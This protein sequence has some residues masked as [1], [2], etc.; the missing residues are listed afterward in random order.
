[1]ASHDMDVS[2]NPGPEGLH[3]FGI[4]NRSSCPNGKS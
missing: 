1:L 2:N 3:L 4:T